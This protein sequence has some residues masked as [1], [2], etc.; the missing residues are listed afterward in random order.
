M[1]RFAT[2]AAIRTAG[3]R[4]RAGREHARA[5]RALASVTR[6]EIVFL[7]ARAGGEVAAGE[8]Q[9]ALGVPAPTL[10]H[11]L[12]ALQRAALVVRRRQGTFVFYAVDRATVSA[13]VRLLTA[14]C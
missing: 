4:A 1:K 13:M 9:R 6:L 5:F 10:S 11:H 12:G 2:A 8:I 7:L 14:C 3:G